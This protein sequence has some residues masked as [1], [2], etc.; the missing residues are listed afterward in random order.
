MSRVSWKTWC[1]FALSM[2][3]IVL[4]I[5]TNFLISAHVYESHQTHNITSSRVPM[6]GK[7]TREQAKSTAGIDVQD[8]SGLCVRYAPRV[9]QA[10][11]TDTPNRATL[12]AQ[13][14]TKHA[15][16]LSIPVTRIARQPLD[17]YTGFLMTSSQGSVTCSVG[18]GLQ[19]PWILEFGKQI[20]GRWLC[21]SVAGPWKGA[22][23]IV[24]DKLPVNL[25]MER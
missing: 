9:L 14:Y 21:S 3:M 5:A 6:S 25:D 18:T 17:E 4:L 12:I 8:A 13:Y 7:S 15:N 20:N 10:Y 1:F 2:L 16:G 11:T 19:A 22:C 23:N 24:G